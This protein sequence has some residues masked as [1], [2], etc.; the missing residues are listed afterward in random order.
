MVPASERSGQPA[1]NGR[2]HDHPAPVLPAEK[3]KHHLGQP[4]GSKYIHIQLPLGFCKRDIFHS[5]IR[6]V[7]R[8]VDQDIQRPLLVQDLLQGILTG[9]F[10]GYIQHERDHSI[11]G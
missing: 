8:I 11:F 9:I 7:P 2:D 4:D 10:L 5:S 1:C 6:S 3:R